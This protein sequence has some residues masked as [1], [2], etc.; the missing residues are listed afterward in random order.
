MIVQISLIAHVLSKNLITHV[1]I[2][3]SSSYL[4]HHVP[5]SV[6]VFI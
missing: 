5:S 3:I 6:R 4:N 1:M 2:E